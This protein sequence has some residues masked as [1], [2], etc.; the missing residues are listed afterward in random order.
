VIRMADIYTQCGYLTV[1]YFMKVAS[2]T[3]L[4]K[5]MDNCK[6]ADIASCKWCQIRRQ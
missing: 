6:M 3:E 5:F 4:C 2:G 1:V